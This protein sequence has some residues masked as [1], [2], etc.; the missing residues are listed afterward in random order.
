[1][2]NQLLVLKPWRIYGPRRAGVHRQS[3]P[4]PAGFSAQHLLVF[5]LKL[6]LDAIRDLALSPL[7]IV[8]FVLDALQRPSPGDSLY[9]KLMALGRRSD[10]MINLFDEFTEGEYYTVDEAVSSVEEAVKPRWEEASR[11]HRRVGVSD[12]EAGSSQ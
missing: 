8:V 10:R 3:L 4:T 9:R 11:K 1:M 5:Q 7:S 6:A 2:L 12:D